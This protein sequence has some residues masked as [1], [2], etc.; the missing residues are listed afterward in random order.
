MITFTFWLSFWQHYLHRDN[1]IPFP[2][3]LANTRRLAAIAEL[4]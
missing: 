2:V 3:R 4:P 1:I